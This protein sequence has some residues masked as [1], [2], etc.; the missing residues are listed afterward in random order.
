MATVVVTIYSTLSGL[1]DDVTRVIRINRFISYNIRYFSLLIIMIIIIIV[2]ILFRWRDNRLHIWECILD[3][4]C[5]TQR[6]GRIGLV[7]IRQ[8]GMY[9]GSC[10]PELILQTFISFNSPRM[11]LTLIQVKVKLALSMCYYFV[12]YFLIGN[13]DDLLIVISLLYFLYKKKLK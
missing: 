3:R 1:L 8:A 11:D 2:D 10:L 6:L 4:P 9:R 13:D 7:N 5:C 12:G